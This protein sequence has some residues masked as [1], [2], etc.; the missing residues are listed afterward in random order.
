MHHD[1]SGCFIIDIIPGRHLKKIKAAAV[2]PR[3]VLASHLSR[4]VIARTSR[5]PRFGSPIISTL[6]T[7]FPD[8][9]LGSFHRNTLAFADARPQPG[10]LFLAQRNNVVRLPHHY[11]SCSDS[12]DSEHGGNRKVKPTT[13]QIKIFPVH[14]SPFRRGQKRRMSGLPCMSSFRSG[15]SV[16]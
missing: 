4:V 7:H 9:L 15:S 16:G 11:R 3:K 10:S 13:S 6:H 2:H 1:A 5:V 12:S 14:F 8:Q